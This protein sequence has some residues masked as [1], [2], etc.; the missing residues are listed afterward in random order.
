M[1]PGAG[2]KTGVEPCARNRT[3]VE[4]GAETESWILNRNQGLGLEQACTMAL[5]LEQALGWN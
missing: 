2:T 3:G 4:P 5:K 1:E